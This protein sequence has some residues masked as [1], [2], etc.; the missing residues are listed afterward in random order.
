MCRNRMRPIPRPSSSAATTISDLSS[1]AGP[2]P[3][4]GTAQIA[5]IHL[6]GACHPVSPNLSILSTASLHTG[7]KA[8][9]SVASAKSASIRSTS[10]RRSLAVLATAP[11]VRCQTRTQG[12]F[13]P[14]VLVLASRTKC[15]L[16][17]VGALF[18]WYI[19][20]EEFTTPSHAQLCKAFK[21]VE[22]ANHG[23]PITCRRSRG[24]TR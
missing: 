16:K 4:F 3:F 8:Q 21:P 7:S 6:D 23:A 18:P 5:L 17:R 15:G 24:F 20:Q 9:S 13:N 19:H 2:H 10:C 12:H 11:S 14:P 22:W 1:S